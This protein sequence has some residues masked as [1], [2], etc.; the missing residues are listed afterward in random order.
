[1]DYI[2]FNTA[3]ILPTK[4]L[5]QYPNKKPWINSSLRK[6]IRSKHHAF[7]AGNINDCH[8]KQA[9]VD[10]IKRAKLEYKNKVEQHFKSNKMKY[11]WKGPKLLT[12][13]KEEQKASS[14]TSTPGSADRLNLFYLWFHNKD[15]S[16]IHQLQKSKLKK[17]KIHEA[18]ITITE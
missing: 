6:L 5:R 17:R 13:Q 10:A 12:G 9:E 16:S 11:A 14:V 7:K 4:T 3:L 2:N 15:Y 8:D 18:Q 1:M